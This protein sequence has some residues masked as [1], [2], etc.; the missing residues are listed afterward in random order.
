M[1]IRPG[2]TLIWLA[3]VL[4]GFSLGVFVWSGIVWLYVVAVI[5]LTYLVV[6]DYRAVKLH[7]GNV[8]VTRTLPGVVG[9]D[10]PFV[11]ELRVLNNSRTL[12][13]GE[14]RDLLPVQAVPAFE[15]HQFTIGAAEVSRSFRS[16]LRIPVRGRYE[17]GPVWL[18][19]RSPRGL[20]E[21]QQSLPCTD[22]IQVLPEIYC[23]QDQLKKEASAQIMQLDKRTQSRQHG[24]G[25]D[26]ESLTEFRQG[27]DPR[28]IDWRTTARYQRPIVRRYQIERYRDLM[29]VV[30]CG[31]L[32]GADAERGTKLD[33]AVDAGLMLAQVALANGDRCGLGVFDDQVVGYLPPVAGIHSIRSLSESMYDLQSRWRESD[34]SQMF[35]ALQAKQSKRSLIVVL[36]DL[37]D[38]ETS[39][40]FR[41]S[42]AAL[43]RRHLVLFVALQTPLL[44][45]ILEAP[46]ASVHDATEKAL[47]FRLLRERER[48][49]HSIKRSGV[50]VL[51]V[52]PRQ[53]TISLINQFIDLRQQN[54]L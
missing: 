29:V 53:L 42:M 35:A 17:F 48:A 36:S 15:T 38:A 27:D 31:R 50:H 20:L 25:S 2:Q 9:R 1:R 41:T 7:A 18:R 52:E 12:L 54:L 39:T 26:F 51:D 24:V 45:G 10:V 4:A 49:L 13:A 43:A 40:R 37:V 46:V 6:V 47:T 30:D 33:S 3:V 22:S 11:A 5:P 14:V 28:R 16:E 44:R 23:S 32:M 21:I 19:L 8:A 34:F